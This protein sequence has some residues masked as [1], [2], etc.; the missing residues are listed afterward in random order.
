MAGR[1][2]VAALTGKRYFS[3]HGKILQDR[4]S[5][6]GVELPIMVNPLYFDF[7]GRFW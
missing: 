1:A 7:P 5:A 2:E 4:I 6:S 3:G